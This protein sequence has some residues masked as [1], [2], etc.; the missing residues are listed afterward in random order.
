MIS[1]RAK[2]RLKEIL[3]DPGL[4]LAATIVFALSVIAWIRVKEGW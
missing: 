2:R 3:K 1:L 4:C